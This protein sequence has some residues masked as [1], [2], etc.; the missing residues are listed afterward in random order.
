[1]RQK[2][3][4]ELG[5]AE[6]LMTQP[7][8]WKCNINWNRVKKTHIGLLGRIAK[9]PKNERIPK[10]AKYNAHNATKDTE[11]Y[12][13]DYIALN[14]KH[15]RLRGGHFDGHYDRKSKPPIISGNAYKRYT[16]TRKQ[17]ANEHTLNHQPQTGKQKEGNKDK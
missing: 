7:P 17:H 10:K 3:R 5:Y 4:G 14:Y 9:D 11:T 6:Q 16:E 12:I 8:T 13:G 15:P 1:M 2:L